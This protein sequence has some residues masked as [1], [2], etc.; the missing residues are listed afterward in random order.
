[1]VTLGHLSILCKLVSSAWAAAVVHYMV[2]MLAPVVLETPAQAPRSMGGRR[3][4]LIFMLVTARSIGRGPTVSVG[5][6]ATA[7]VARGRA[8]L[9]HV[10]GH[11]CTGGARR[12]CSLHEGTLSRRALPI[13]SSSSHWK[14]TAR[15]ARLRLWSPFVDFLPLTL[16][17]ASDVRLSSCLCDRALRQACCLPE[18]SSCS[19]S[20]HSAN[21]SSF[22]W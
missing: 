4:V 19:G 14:R 7:S 20:A 15:H 9:S 8:T 12:K 13:Q 10:S 17:T 3:G 22:M 6:A 5:P 11:P 18:D 21:Q 1:M 2:H 16:L